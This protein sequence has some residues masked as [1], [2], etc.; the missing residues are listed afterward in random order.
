MK[1]SKGLIIIGV[2]ILILIVGSVT[3]ALFYK[4]HEPISPELI[5]VGK[6]VI[7]LYPTRQEVVSIKLNFSGQLICTYPDYKN[8]WNVVAAPDGTLTNLDDKKQYACLFWD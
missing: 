4:Q 5:L 2:F 6:P 1:L 3:W 7:Y 8:G